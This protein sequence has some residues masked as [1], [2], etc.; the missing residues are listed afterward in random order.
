MK[1]VTGDSDGSAAIPHKL[2]TSRQTQCHFQRAFLRARIASNLVQHRAHTEP[3][4][5]IE[6]QQS[7][8]RSSDGRQWN[9]TEAIQ[10]E[11]LAHF[12]SRG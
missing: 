11:V 9:N 8:G 10:T 3:L 12:W 1:C 4:G 7:D 5:R 2:S 6:A